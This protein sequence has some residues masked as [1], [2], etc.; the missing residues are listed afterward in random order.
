MIARCGR[1][2]FATLVMGA[3]VACG[4]L[5]LDGALPPLENSGSGGSC[6]AAPTSAS[7]SGGSVCSGGA[8]GCPANSTACGTPPVCIDTAN[9]AAHCG[10]CDNACP[11][12]MV[13]NA[14]TCGCP[15]SMNECSGACSNPKVD[16]LN[17][18]GCGMA[19]ATGQACQGGGCK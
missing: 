6:S 10:G 11:S 7:G 9:S 4:E 8:G 18:G 5:S 2:V 19:C 1:G 12:G 14:S 13:C 17:C 15:P 16:P 3:L